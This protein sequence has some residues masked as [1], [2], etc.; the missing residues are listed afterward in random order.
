MVLSGSENGKLTELGDGRG[1]PSVAAAEDS[2]VVGGFPEGEVMG[3]LGLK[4]R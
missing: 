2:S 4:S 3:W 1:L